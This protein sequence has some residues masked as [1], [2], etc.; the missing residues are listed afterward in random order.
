MILVCSCVGRFY[1]EITKPLVD[2][3]CIPV[4]GLQIKSVVREPS[5]VA[6][7]GYAA[8]HQSVANHCE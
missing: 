8:A 5:L 7:V 1:F 6:A 3:Q 4:H 2:V